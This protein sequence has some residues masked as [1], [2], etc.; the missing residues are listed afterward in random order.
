[1]TRQSAGMFPPAANLTTSPGTT[2]FVGIDTSRPSRITVVRVVTSESSFSS[3][4]A[5]PYSCQNPNIALTMMI[6]KMIRA[7]ALSLRKKDS[8]AAKIRIAVMGL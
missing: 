8:N 7:S 3:A 1:M 4:L 2:S 5:A 6:V